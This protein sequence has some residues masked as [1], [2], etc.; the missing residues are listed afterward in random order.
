[1][2]SFSAYFMRLADRC[3]GA[4]RR[5]FDLDAVAEF[6]KLAGELI[7]KAEELEH[8]GTSVAVT[9]KVAKRKHRAVSFT[10][11]SAES[12]S[13]TRLTRDGRRGVI[14]AR[15]TRRPAPLSQAVQTSPA[16]RRRR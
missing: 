4:A 12:A 3:I 7:R 11:A 15:C 5:S 14:H 8:I 1:M 6:R 10:K 9:S 13:N 2:A 16:S